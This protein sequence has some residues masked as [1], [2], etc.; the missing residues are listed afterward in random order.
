MAASVYE[1]DS[2]GGESCSDRTRE[3]AANPRG[4]LAVSF[5]VSLARSFLL[6]GSLREALC[7]SLLVCYKYAGTSLCSSVVRSG[8]ET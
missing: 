5:H 7:I 2:C 4:S 1:R 8:R 3:R 6:A